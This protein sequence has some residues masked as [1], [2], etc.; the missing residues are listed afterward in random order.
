MKT[1]WIALGALAVALSFAP[2]AQAQAENPESDGVRPEQNDRRQGRRRGGGGRRGM[3]PA[4]MQEE[5]G[6]SDEQVAQMQQMR[7]EMRAEMR[8]MRESGEGFNREAMQAMREKMQGKMQ[9]ILT[10]EQLEKYQSMRG[11]RDRGGRDRGG[12]DRKPK[13]DLKA[14]A[15]TA[16]ALEGDAKVVVEP[17]IEAVVAA[18]KAQGEAVR[19]A[20]DTLKQAIEGQTDEGAITTAVAEFR[21]AR[22][23]ARAKTEEAQGDLRELLTVEQEAKLVALGLLD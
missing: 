4:R 18:R 8:A 2:A 13:R 9:E 12:R 7:E 22:D 17:M 19:S 16:L 14:E 20:R 6:L 10:P 5:L 11:R 15:L 23:E 21:K 1:T 3:D